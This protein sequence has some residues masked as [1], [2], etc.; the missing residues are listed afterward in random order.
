MKVPCVAK[1]AKIKKEISI[2]TPNTGLSGCTLS[3]STSS[4]STVLVPSSNA[5]SPGTLQPT[6][7]AAA[8]PSPRSMDTVHTTQ[9]DIVHESRCMDASP[10][11]SVSGSVS[12]NES[13]STCDSL[14]S[15]EFEY[16]DSVEVSGVKSI[17]RKTS[18]SLY[19]SDDL[20][21]AGLF[22]LINKTC[23]ILSL[24]LDHNICSGI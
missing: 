8:L 2:R 18:K 1:T 16:I 11:R 9:N 4:K 7:E 13:M 23:L 19:I 20:E 24:I 6:A 3:A 22:F 5:S 15:A 10:C 17:E 12:L 14:T 21:V